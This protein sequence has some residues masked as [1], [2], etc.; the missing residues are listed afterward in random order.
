V[1]HREHHDKTNSKSTRTSSWTS[2]TSIK[3]N[4]KI[5]TDIA[6]SIRILSEALVAKWAKNLYFALYFSC[7]WLCL[8][9][10]VINGF[11]LSH[12]V[13]E[14]NRT[15]DLPHSR[16]AHYPLHHRYGS[17]ERYTHCYQV[18]TVTFKQNELDNFLCWLTNNLFVHATILLNNY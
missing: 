17:T 2:F 3:L 5:I 10:L 14:I 8:R 7:N 4:W 11:P 1:Q 18:S 9:L 6:K 13:D 15:H 16:R 12:I